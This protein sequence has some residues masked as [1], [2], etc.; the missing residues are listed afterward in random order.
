M[1]AVETVTPPGSYQ[2]LTALLRGRLPKLASGQLRIAHLVLADP[3]GTAYRGIAEAAQLVEVR[4]SSITRFANS[5]G[6]PGYP[7]IMEL[8]RVWLAEQAQAARHVDAGVRE[9][10]GGLLSATLEQEQTNLAHTFNRLDRTS[11]LRAVALLAEADAA[12]VLGV[13]ASR[14]I[15]DLLS[16]ALGARRLGESLADEVRQLSGVL[17]AVSVRRYA[18]DTVRAVAYAREH[19]VNVVAL[20]DDPAS[21]LVEHAHAA[22]FAETTG[23]GTCHS[24]TALTALAQA[25]A[26]EVALRR[27][28]NSPDDDLPPSFGFFY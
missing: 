5:L 27:G 16:R 12:Q 19:G 10:P 6:L 4:E 9:P 28:E 1:E 24:L 8:C 2:E 23:P 15:A 3:E 26:R 11:W 21:P 25:L 17:V 20:T 7:A 14:P 13:R 22:L 18:A